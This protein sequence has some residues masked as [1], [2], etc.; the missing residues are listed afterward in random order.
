[1]LDDAEEVEE[2]DGEEQDISLPEGKIGAKKRAKL[3][4]KAAKK[5]ARE[6]EELIRKKKKQAE[7][8]AE[9]ERKKI[10][11]KETVRHGYLKNILKLLYLLKFYFE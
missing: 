7:A 11:E 10:I 9:E 4:A 2:D 6:A 1:M 5:S 8:E 3:E